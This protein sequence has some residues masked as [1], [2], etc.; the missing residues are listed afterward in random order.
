MAVAGDDSA[1]PDSGVR[2]LLPARYRQLLARSVHG[3]VT[4]ATSAASHHLCV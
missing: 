4:G 3:D 1:W 2:E